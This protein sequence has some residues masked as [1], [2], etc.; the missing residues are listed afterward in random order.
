ML[1]RAHAA[2]TIIAFK[3]RS[4]SNEDVLLAEWAQRVA[5]RRTFVEF[6]FGPLEMNCG[7]L[8]RAGWSGMLI[9]ARRGLAD[10]LLDLRLRRVRVEQRWLTLETLDVITNR[11]GRGDLGALSVDVDGNDYWLLQA[12]LPLEPALVMVEYNASLLHHPVT[13]PYDPRFD[14]FSAHPAGYYHG[15][16]L[17]ALVRLCR[18]YSLAAV[19]DD[20]VNALFVRDDLTDTPALDPA[21]AWRE[22]SMRNEW[23][24]TSAVEQW[25]EIRDLPY[26]S[27][28]PKSL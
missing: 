25:S 17:E 3:P 15:A 22:N 6:G 13:V 23:S 5:C 9:D 20:G 8:I 1:K 24:Q 11:H 14:R 18:G 28:S 10:R 16:S 4:Q 19:A 2:A 21:E 12:L 27:V 7:R 26:I